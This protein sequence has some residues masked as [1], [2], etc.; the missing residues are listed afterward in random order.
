MISRC[1]FGGG[2]AVHMLLLKLH[3]ILVGAAGCRWCECVCV[4]C[5]PACCAARLKN[6]ATR[7]LSFSHLEMNCV[8]E[9]SSRRCVLLFK[10]RWV[11]LH[12][13]SRAQKLLLFTTF[14]W[15][16]CCKKFMALASEQ[17]NWTLIEILPFCVEDNSTGSLRAKGKLLKIN[18]HAHTG[19]L[20]FAVY[21]SA[22]F[23]FISVCIIQS[24]R[25]DLFHFNI[26]IY[27]SIFF[28]GGLL[29]KLICL[30]AASSLLLFSL[31]NELNLGFPSWAARNGFA[32]KIVFHS[33]STTLRDFFVFLLLRRM[34]S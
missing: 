11:V 18:N 21:L 2:G 4:P 24:N 32:R 8:S 19:S 5:A 13:Y 1:S 28:R 31:G 7:P 10:F 16:F 17:I 23:V 6:E 14:M 20:S 33:F 26:K 3:F 12:D 30:S 25:R 29:W 27:D 34:K 22:R 15:P 9:R